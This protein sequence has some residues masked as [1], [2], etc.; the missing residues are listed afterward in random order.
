MVPQVFKKYGFLSFDHHRLASCTSNG[1]NAE[2]AFGSFSV[3]P[4]VE[5]YY[6]PH[7]LGGDHEVL[8]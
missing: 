8:R 6:G 4:V 5:V 2:Q 1:I 7:P 3:C